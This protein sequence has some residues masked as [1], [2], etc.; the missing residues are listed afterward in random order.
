VADPIAEAFVRI[1]PDFTGFDD[2]VRRKIDTA[3]SGA[4]LSPSSQKNVAA[5]IF[6][7]GF[8]QETKTKVTGAV[9]DVD[10]PSTTG[11]KLAK[12]LFGPGF[13]NETGRAIQ[14]VLVGAG[15]GQL[16][17]QFAF[18]GAG[19]AALAVLA[20]GF[21]S[22]AQASAEFERSL[23][24]LQATAQLS[25]DELARFAKEARDLGADVR[26]PGVTAQEA[27]DAFGELAKAGLSAADALEAGRGV[28]QLSI[29]ANTDA[30]NAARIAAS[31]LN[32]F[33]LAGVEAVHVADLLAGASIA[34]QG[35]IGDMAL[36][37]QQS[38]AVANQAGLSI[39][40]L[41]GL[42]T[43][44]AQK[45]L[46][47]SDAGTSIR[48]AL[49]RLIPTTK[50]AAQIMQVLGIQIDATRTLGEQLPELL[51]QYRLAL[52]RLNPTAR[53]AALLQIFGTDA[54]RSATIAIEGG[55]R[56]FEASITA[57]NRQGAAAELA[58]A[59]SKGL[60]GAL[61]GLSSTVQTLSV[62]TGTILSPALE[63]VVRDL[64][65]II[66][67]A[68]EAAEALNR[69]G[70][71][72]IPGTDFGLGRIALRIALQFNPITQIPNEVLLAR[73]ALEALGAD[74]S[75]LEATA[76]KKLNERI[77]ELNAEL[78]A[79]GTA[80][81]RRVQIFVEIEGLEKAV[82]DLGGVGAVA[83]SVREQVAQLQK[84]LFTLGTTRA[85]RIAIQ[86]RIAE[87]EKQLEGLPAKA[88]KA[89]KGFTDPFTGSAFEGALTPPLDK[90]QAQ[91]EEA[92]VIDPNRLGGQLQRAIAALNNPAVGAEAKKVAQLTAESLIAELSKLG[93]EGE[94]VL[95]AAGVRM[96]EALGSGITEAE[97]RAITAARTALTRV[98][99][100]G[101]RQIQ[102]A[103][104]SARGNLE[105]LGTSISDSLQD[106]FDAGPAPTNIRRQI[107]QVQRDVERGLRFNLAGAKRD[108]AIAQASIAQV[109]TLT[110]AQRARQRE[111]LLPFQESLAEAKEAIK[112]FRTDEAIT[113]IDKLDERL[114]DLQDATQR[115]QLRFDLGQARIDLREAQEAIAQVGK[116]TPEQKRSQQEFLAPF[117][118]RIADAK[119]AADEFELTKQ[120]DELEK[121]R[122]EAARAAEEGIQKLIQSFQDGK[123]SAEEFNRLLRD[124]LGPALDTLKTKGGQN[125]GLVFTRDFKRDVEALIKQALA[126]SSF[127]PLGGGTTPG[128]QVVRPAETQQQV[129]Q[130]IAEAA[131]SLAQIQRDAERLSKEEQEKLETLIG[132][133][134][135]IARALEARLPKSAAPLAGPK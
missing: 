100:E 23:N 69:L 18:F 39:E 25:D 128:A 64:T 75:S 111:F 76:A 92:L 13:R 33:S 95:R 63:E 74:F 30:A 116:L 125:L 22:A 65:A 48:T 107:Q 127:F 59:K 86:E 89:A 70:D 104:R 62:N 15:G 101:E 51:D 120:R 119:A 21:V 43:E 7:T 82:E 77:A 87:L 8:Q 54:I 117:R 66:A 38:A 6:G 81:A 115:R 133:Q 130:R 126:L 46:I 108:L 132:L 50:E 118:E 80:P 71:I 56:A 60:A 68:N 28:L 93:P 99:E 91:L 94:R 55:A 44:L 53:Q 4:R 97:Q 124:Q 26:L 19:G 10:L 35:D 79:I 135:R 123:V 29:A 42:I 57:A 103:I 106:I 17:A 1:R 3:I 113:E 5:Q 72:E 102:D 14:G 20:T 31:A 12:A 24:V 110:P 90:L 27:A 134:R 122:V 41:V 16:A 36:A 52:S 96:M 105:S 84:E 109:G 114:Q 85:E 58:T 9:D 37:L 121:T 83:D 61:E 88:K 131:A 73:D 78:T 129:N 11:Q 34:A 32:A 2:E 40:Q 49:L 67:P 112:T 98:R 47:G 45:G